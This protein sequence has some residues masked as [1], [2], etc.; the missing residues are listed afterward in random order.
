MHEEFADKKK[1]ETNKSNQLT[2]NPPS[3][4]WPIIF[5]QIPDVVH[6]NQICFGRDIS[7]NSQAY[8][9]C[10]GFKGQKNWSC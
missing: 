1:Q 7:W 3:N 8:L 10:H 6:S 9:T 2:A 4:Y 5:C